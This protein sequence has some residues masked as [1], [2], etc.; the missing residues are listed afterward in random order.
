MAIS[1]KDRNKILYLRNEGKA[2]SKIQSDDFPNLGYW[3]IMGVIY[4]KGVRAALGTKRMIANRCKWIIATKSDQDRARWAREI[5]DLAWQLYE[6]IKDNQKRLE[7]IR[8]LT[9]LQNK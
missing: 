8:N 9:S 7:E 3:E 1:E 2:C 5:N 4:G 6:M